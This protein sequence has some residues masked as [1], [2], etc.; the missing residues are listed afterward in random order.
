M[1]QGAADFLSKPVDEKKSL[2]A[3]LKQYKSADAS[4]SLQDIKDRLLFIMAI[5][6]VRCV[7]EGVLRSTGDANIGAAY[8]IGYPQWTG[9]T[10]QF[11]NQYGLNKFIARAN[12]LAQRYGE[13]FTVPTLVTNM[14]NEN[15]LF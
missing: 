5:E 11:I 9:G 8:G 4:I 10:L 3:G 12:E 13:R 15:K 1:K 14:A 6:T 2:W 7:E